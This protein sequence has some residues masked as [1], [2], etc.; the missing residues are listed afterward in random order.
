[1]FGLE[2]IIE[3]SANVLA[4]AFSIFVIGIIL[5]ARKTTI[6]ARYPKFHGWLIVTVF[7]YILSLVASLVGGFYQIHWL[8]E[9]VHHVLMALVVIFLA[10]TFR[11]YNH[12]ISKDAQIRGI[13]ENIP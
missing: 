13:Q 11:A 3:V 4:V 1:M 10:I 6:G 2:D 8:G 5:T 9:V 12:E 7:I